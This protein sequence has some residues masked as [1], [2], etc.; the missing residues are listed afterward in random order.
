MG[1]QK[2][3]SICTWCLKRNL[4][5]LKD[6][7]RVY[8]SC[9]NQ[10]IIQQHERICSPQNRVQWRIQDITECVG[11]LTPDAGT[12]TYYY[13]PQTKLLKVMCLHLSVSHSVHRGKGSL[14]NVTSCLAA[15]P[16]VPSGGLC[17]WSHVPSRGSLGGLPDR[18]PP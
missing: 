5:D 3:C 15:W 7:E 1:A 13:R 16:H 11:A 17:L 4:C 12:K 14:Y 6:N 8:R 18:D 10:F 9:L 2:V